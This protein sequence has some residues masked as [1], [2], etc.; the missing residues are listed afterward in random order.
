MM[1]VVLRGGGKTTFLRPNKKVTLRNESCQMSSLCL[2]HIPGILA[3]FVGLG[4]DVEY[5]AL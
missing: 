4:L 3:G 1:G 2:P 5:Y